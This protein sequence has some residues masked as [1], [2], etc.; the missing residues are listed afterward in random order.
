MNNGVPLAKSVLQGG[1]CHSSD[2]FILLHWS[3]GLV[4]QLLA[5]EE[6]KKRGWRLHTQL[7]AW[8][9]QDGDQ[10]CIPLLKLDDAE[11]VEPPPFSP[12]PH[13]HTP[14]TPARRGRARI[15]SHPM[16]CCTPDHT[17]CLFQLG[18]FPEAQ[19]TRQG[20]IRSSE[21]CTGK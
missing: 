18:L 19:S 15:R 6:L 10:V 14:I 20:E 21:V 7:N 16:P 4:Q 8:F 2:T 13:T 5:A 9:C 3:Q 1:L 11:I 12:P 17:P